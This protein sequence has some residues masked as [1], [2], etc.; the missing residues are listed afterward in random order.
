MAVAI[1]AISGLGIQTFRLQS[2]KL[3]TAGA[4]TTLAQERAT[5]AAAL[6][7]QTETH[8]KSEQKLMAGATETRKKIND[9]INTLNTHNTSLLQRV[10]NAKATAA[11]CMPAP[12]AVASNGQTVAGSAQPELLGSPG[13]ADVLEASRADTIRLHLEGCY[14]DYDR[15]EEALKALNKAQ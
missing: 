13:E 11:A 5:A 12:T 1:V 15:A 2:A 4:V 7:K 10:R 6:A 8:R 14:R 3:E 9:E